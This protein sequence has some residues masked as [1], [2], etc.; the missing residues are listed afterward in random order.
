MNDLLTVVEYGIKNSRRRNGEQSIHTFPYRF[1]YS[2]QQDG[3]RR[4]KIKDSKGSFH[5]N[6]RFTKDKSRF[7]LFQKKQKTEDY[8]YFHIVPSMEREDP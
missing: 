7:F 6:P 2:F 8:P 3:C 1:P 4:G 5:F